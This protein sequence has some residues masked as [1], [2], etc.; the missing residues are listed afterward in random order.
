MDAKEDLQT[1]DN[2][3][4]CAKWDGRHD[5]FWEAHYVGADR[6]YCHMERLANLSSLPPAG[7]TVC[8]FPLKVVGGSAGP[9]RI[10]AILDSE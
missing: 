7:F 10:V 6:E 3:I 5:L 9:S 2:T 8:A 4:C 1:R